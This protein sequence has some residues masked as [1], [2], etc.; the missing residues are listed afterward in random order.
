MPADGSLSLSQR[1][2][3]RHTDPG[4]H[5]VN[6]SEMSATGQAAVYTGARQV[7]SIAHTHGEEMLDGYAD[8][9]G[10]GVSERQKAL[11]SWIGTWGESEVGKERK[12]RG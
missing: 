3:E 4:Y 6:R 1:P 11:R 2:W 8:G 5:G 10:L 9:K 7:T 12:L